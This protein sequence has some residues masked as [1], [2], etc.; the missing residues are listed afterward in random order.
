MHIRI[1]FSEKKDKISKLS[2]T[3]LAR[4]GKKTY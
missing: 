1:D 3:V 4:V 2:D